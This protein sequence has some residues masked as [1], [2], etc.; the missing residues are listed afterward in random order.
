MENATEQ[1]LL[2]HSAKPFDQAARA[3][4]DQ[5][6]ILFQMMR[7]NK[8]YEKHPTHQAL[9]DALM[10]S[11]IPDKEYMEKAK[12]V[13]PP[14]QKK[15]RHDDNNQDPPAGPDHGLKEKKTHK[16]AE[17]SKRPKSTGSSK[18][19]TQSQPKPTGKSV[20][21]EETVFEDADTDMP[22][23]QGD[24]M[25]NTDE[26][27]DVEAVTK[28]DWFKKPSR[29]HTL[30]PEWNTRKSIDDGPEQDCLNDLAN[31]ENPPLTFDDLMRTPIDFSAFSMNCLKISKLT[32]AD[33][34]RP[35]Y[36][37][38]KGT[39]K[40]CV[41]LECNMEECYRALSD[42]LYWNNPEGNHCPYDLNKPLPLHESREGIEDMVPKLWSPIKVAY[43]KYAALGISHKRPKHQRFYGHMINKV[44]RHDVYSTMS[45][46]S[47][48]SVTVDKW[49]GYGHLKEI[50]VR[51]VDTK[52][53]KFMEGDFPRLHLNDI[54]DML[55]LVVQN[56]LFN[57]E[58]DVIVDLAVALH[59][60]TQ[61]IV[62][63][64]RVEDLQLGVES[65]QKKLNISK[66]QTRDIDISF[67]ELYTTHSEPQ[68]V[69]YEDK[70]K[71]KILTRTNELYKFNDG[72]L[73]SVRKTL[74]Q[75]LTNFRIGYN[76][77]MKR[78]LWTKTDQKRTRIMI[79]DI[80]QQLLERRIMRSLEKFIGGRDYGTDIRLLQWKI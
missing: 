3:E 15:R 28:D 64:K 14:T 7:E 70:L 24:D 75:R 22:L 26:Q 16:D 50:V 45:I 4:F 6:E 74:Q 34:V 27:P 57:L 5:K 67:K 19:T 77:A 17:P 52:L 13:A 41:E 51:R 20:Q 56:M 69:I 1:Q 58:G 38:L 9:Y 12:T 73:D 21:A 62:I 61:R 43:D 46:L 80:D 49:Y 30:D 65:Y 66:P 72:T 59:M 47:V 10:Q 31:T 76:K 23:N 68:G 37:L 40:S 79:K 29:T 33:L 42:Q 35:V 53:Y 36:N 2:K 25:G 78:R 32:K 63:Q 60:Y 48:M 8:S 11:L 44:S 54:E 71:R 55:L 39:C 18:G